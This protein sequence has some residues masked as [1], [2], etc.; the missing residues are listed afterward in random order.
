M[1]EILFT[2]YCANRTAYTVHHNLYPAN[3]FNPNISS[4]GRF[5]PFIDSAGK[6]VPTLYASDTPNG[7]LFETLFRKPGGELHCATPININSFVDRSISFWF[8]TID[9]TLAD[10]T[11]VT[12]EYSEIRNALVGSAI[13]YPRARVLAKII[14]DQT[15]AHGITWNGRQIDMVGLTNMVLFGDRVLPDQINVFKTLPLQVGDGYRFLKLAA[16]AAK[17]TL[18]ENS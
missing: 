12:D 15:D 13:Y 10:F 2:S 5:H 4:V 9:L 18:P 17:R 6:I 3:S 11:H 1:E 7:A 8:P 16:T 14:H